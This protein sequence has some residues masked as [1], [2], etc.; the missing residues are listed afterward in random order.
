M[1][2]GDSPMTWSFV[3]HRTIGFHSDASKLGTTFLRCD[4]SIDF[5]TLPMAYQPGALWG[6]F[7]EDVRTLFQQLNPN[8]FIQKRQMHL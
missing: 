4:S 1:V 8:Y 5:A 6:N 2:T 3:L 7:V